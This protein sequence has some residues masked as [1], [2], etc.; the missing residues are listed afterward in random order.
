MK[1]FSAM[2]MI[3]LLLTASTAAGYWYFKYK[4]LSGRFAKTFYSSGVTVD[5]VVIPKSMTY[6]EHEGRLFLDIRIVQGWLD[7]GAY[8]S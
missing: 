8:V 4:D 6:I 7:D 3:L 1:R 2:I 5:D